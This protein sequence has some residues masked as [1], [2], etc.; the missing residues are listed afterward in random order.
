MYYPH[1]PHLAAHKHILRYLQGTPELGLLRRSST[2][3]L[4][5]YTNV[6]WAG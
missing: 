6:V 3:E 5:I 1:E 4:V 2:T